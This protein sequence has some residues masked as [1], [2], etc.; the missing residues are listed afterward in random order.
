MN[1]IKK[2][3]GWCSERI[4]ATEAATAVREFMAPYTQWWRENEKIAPL[5]KFLR[6]HGGKITV[7]AI[8]IF[9]IFC[10]PFAGS[11][12]Y[13]PDK[14]EIYRYDSDVT[15]TLTRDDPA[16]H[17][18]YRSLKRGG[19]TYLYHF[20][21][22]FAGKDDVTIDS[23]CG[24]AY[25]GLYDTH[26]NPTEHNAYEEDHWED[27]IIV[28]AY[29]DEMQTVRQAIG[30][31]RF[32]SQYNELTFVL[33]GAQTPD[34]KTLHGQNEAIVSYQTPRPDLGEN[35][36]SWSAFNTWHMPKRAIRTIEKL[37]VD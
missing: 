36:Y 35:K 24:C 6:F 7:A 2:F 27:F 8:V 26:F 33:P 16:F 30:F 34:Q 20:P 37:K 31:R 14:M 1:K 29:Y 21:A 28:R 5:R 11:P 22:I 25:E 32:D 15:V 18:I 13:K 17:T 12:M 3:F 19:A 23:Y 4:A 10:V 9:V